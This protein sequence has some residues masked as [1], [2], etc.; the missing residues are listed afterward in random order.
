VSRKAIIQGEIHISPTDRRSLMKRE[1]NQYQALYCEGRSGRISPHYQ[2]NRYNF[3][4]I[5]ILTLKLFYGIVAYIYTNLFPKSGY[6]IES[7]AKDAGL[8]FDDNIDVEID[9]I[10]DSYN[11]QTVNNTL[12]GLILLFVLLFW[13][14]FQVDTLNFVIVSTSIPFWILPFVYAILLPFV[15]SSLLISFANTGDRDEKMAHSI[16]RK[17]DERDH[18]S[19]LILVGEKHVEPIGEMLDDEGWEVEKQRSN[20]ILGRISQC[21]E[22]D[23]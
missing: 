10:F 17:C 20:N 7:Q 16:M 1:T 11:T 3:Y 12:I 4:V 9:E 14:S 22:F 19:I 23:I 6:D 5:G 18:D 21:L 8:A 2:Q 15:Y 13:Y